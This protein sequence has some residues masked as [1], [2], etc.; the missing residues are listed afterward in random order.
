MFALKLLATVVVADLV[1]GLVHWAEDAYARPDASW[2]G[3]I[4]RD[5]LLH[6]TRPREFLKKTWWQSSGDLLAI[7]IAVIAVAAL[8]GH[9]NGWV[10]LFVAITANANQIHKWAHSSRHEK[11]A[12]VY[13]LQR[14]HILQ[15]ARHHARHHSG[16]KN[17]HY[18]VV[19]NIVNPVLEAIRFWTTLER[20]VL[21]TT[22]VTRRDDGDYA[23]K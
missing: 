9:F 14:A 2:F 8:T 16:Q 22:G 23:T 5:N 21:K 10:L 15:S 18:C 20:V 13:W 17:T 6:H 19:T 12:I 3:Q 4:A 1:A 7:G 11:P